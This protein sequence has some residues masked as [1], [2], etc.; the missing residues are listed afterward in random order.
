MHTISPAS[1]DRERIVHEARGGAVVPPVLPPLSVEFESL[2]QKTRAACPHHHRVTERPNPS[3]LQWIQGQSVQ[4]KCKIY[5]VKR[6]FLFSY[7]YSDDRERIV[8]EA[9]GGAVVPPVLPPLSVE[10]ESL[11]Q[12]TRAACPHHHRVTERQK[13]SSLQ[14]IQGQSV[15][16]KCGIYINTFISIKF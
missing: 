7:I 5:I 16:T 12:K 9:C 3:F 6:Y 14:W 8:H 2:A 11:A 10:F 13:P 1:D 4:T 15:Q